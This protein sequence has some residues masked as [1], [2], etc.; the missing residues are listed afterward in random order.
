MAIWEPLYK[1]QTLPLVVLYRILIELGSHR[2]IKAK[3]FCPKVRQVP[4]YYQIT[5][6][7]L[8]SSVLSQV[9]HVPLKLLHAL[10][11]FTPRLDKGFSVDVIYPDFQN[12]FDSV[13]HQSLI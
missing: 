11:Y 2:S 13:P 8:T 9:D 12:A 3:H 6:S 7:H 4:L 10:D 1:G 5:Y